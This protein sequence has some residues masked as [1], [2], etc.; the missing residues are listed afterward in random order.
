MNKQLLSVPVAQSLLP[1]KFK[2]QPECELIPGAPAEHFSHHR[3]KWL[4]VSTAS[5][6]DLDDYH[7]PIRDFFR[8]PSSTTDWLAHL[9]EKGWFDSQDFFEM[10]H[11]FRKATDSFGGI[12]RS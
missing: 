10:L 11:R 7:F 1:L 3:E 9:S 4:F 6:E 8:S 12:S 5:P 2:R